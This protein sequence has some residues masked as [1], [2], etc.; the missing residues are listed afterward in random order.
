M[1]HI[2]WGYRDELRRLG[3]LGEF[4]SHFIQQDEGTVF[5]PNWTP[6]NLATPPV[7]WLDANDSDSFETS[8]G[9]NFLNGRIN[10]TPVPYGFLLAIGRAPGLRS[11]VWARLTL[12]W[13]TNEFQYQPLGSG[14]LS[15]SALYIVY[16][17]QTSGLN[18]SIF[19]NGANWRSHGPWNNG[20]VFWDVGT[21]TGYRI[22]AANWATAG[23]SLIGMWY[24]SA[25]ENVQQVWKNGKLYV[26]DESGHTTSIT[27]DFSIGVS[28]LNALVGEVIL[29]KGV[30]SETDRKLIDEYLM[31]KWDL[32]DRRVS[33]DS[34]GGNIAAKLVGGATIDRTVDAF[35]EGS[36]R[37]NGSD[38][39]AQVRSSAYPTRRGCKVRRFGLV[40][41]LG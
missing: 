2:F 33:Q 28:Q 40:V 29:L 32:S 12:M 6:Q 10:L 24:N 1:H 22:N 8:M 37:L 38:A 20:Y 13:G 21:D 5:D 3:R 7:L 14:N 41:A 36:L 17:L 25:T 39:W 18:Q 34:S 15:D 31:A 4:D 30:L 35:G 27:G 11:T 19:N 9:T 16:T 26:A 23:E